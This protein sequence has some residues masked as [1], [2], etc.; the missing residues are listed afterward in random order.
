MET[1][2][3]LVII[4][5]VVSILALF[6]KGNSKEEAKKIRNEMVT[7]TL[8]KMFLGGVIGIVIASAIGIPMLIHS[9]NE[10]IEYNRPSVSHYNKE[11][12]VNYGF[13]WNGEFCEREFD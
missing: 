4:F 1:F 9:F 3:I 10:P 6:L 2:F 11:D 8:G 12:C 7:G 13:V 5:I